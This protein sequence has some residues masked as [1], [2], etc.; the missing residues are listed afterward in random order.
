MQLTRPSVEEL[1]CLYISNFIIF[2]HLTD[3]SI[4]G[5]INHSGWFFFFGFGMVVWGDTSGGKSNVM[6]NFAESAILDLS[7]EKFLPV[8]SD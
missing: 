5:Q 7:M 6:V 1:N 4:S 3:S 8:W 2:K